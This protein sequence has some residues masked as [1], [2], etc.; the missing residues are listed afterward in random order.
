MLQWV[1]KGVIFKRESTFS[2]LHSNIRKY[3]KNIRKKWLSL[4]SLKIFP[5]C[6]QYIVQYFVENT[7]INCH[8]VQNLYILDLYVVELKN[9]DEIFATNVKKI[10]PCCENTGKMYNKICN[11]DMVNIFPMCNQYLLA[12]SLIIIGFKQNETIIDIILIERYL[13]LNVFDF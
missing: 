12:T 5:R 11:Q 13:G 2:N 4:N 8:C 6:N 9:F 7:L 1:L 3:Q 10:Q